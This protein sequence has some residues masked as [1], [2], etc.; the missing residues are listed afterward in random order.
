[1]L[2][3]CHLEVSNRA[4]DDIAKVIFC[5]NVNVKFHAASDS[6]CRRP[7]RLGASGLTAGETEEYDLWRLSYFTAFTSRGWREGVGGG[8]ILRDQI[9]GSS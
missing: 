1:M 4:V 7:E 9:N 2:N 8:I 3:L 5:L 6:D